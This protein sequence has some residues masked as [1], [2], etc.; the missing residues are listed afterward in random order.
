[1]PTA[2]FPKDKQPIVVS[3]HP[4]SGTHL[5]I[6]LLRRQYKACN[7]PKTLDRGLDDLYFSIEGLFCPMKNLK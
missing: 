3:S 6:D 7:I 1:M 4:R 2:L 5:C